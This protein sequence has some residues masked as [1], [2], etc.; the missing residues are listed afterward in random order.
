VRHTDCAGEIGQ[1]DE[2][3]LERSDEDGVELGVVARD[4]LAE[5][6][7]AAADLPAVEVDLADALRRYDTSSSLYRS[8]RRLMSRL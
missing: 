6:G 7:D 8:A 4:V 5:L 3:R 2:A 1:E